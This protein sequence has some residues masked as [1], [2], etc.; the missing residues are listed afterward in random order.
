MMGH[1]HYRRILIVLALLFLGARAFLFNTFSG[2][3]KAVAIHVPV[4]KGAVFKGLI[5]I[6]IDFEGLA[7]RHLDVIKIGITGYA[8][9]LSRDG[10]QLHSPIKGLTRLLRSANLNPV[11]FS[12]PREFLERHDPAAIG[13]RVMDAAMPAWMGCSCNRR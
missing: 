10:T 8:W 1:P 5:G 9:V 4:F 11:A 13:C 12:S 2:D 6:L 3:A 7:K